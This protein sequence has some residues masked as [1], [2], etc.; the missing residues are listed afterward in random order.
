MRCDSPTHA[1]IGSSSSGRLG[2]A[3]QRLS[4]FELALLAWAEGGGECVARGSSP[5]AAMPCLAGRA[6]T[7]RARSAR[8]AEGMPH[9]PAL[10]AHFVEGGDSRSTD[11]IWKERASP[12][13]PGPAWAVRDVRAGEMYGKPG[14]GGLRVR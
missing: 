8:D 10:P 5:T 14:V 12:A 13:A 6:G 4:M 11:V 2:S 1:A 7:R 3:G 9:A